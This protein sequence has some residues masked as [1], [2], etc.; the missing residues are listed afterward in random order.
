MNLTVDFGALL[1]LVNPLV[2]WV[3]GLLIAAW[4]AGVAA[5]M[6]FLKGSR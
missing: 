2:F 1:G 3:P 5:L 4:A 6:L